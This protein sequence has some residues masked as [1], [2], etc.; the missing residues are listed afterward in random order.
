MIAMIVHEL[1]TNAVKCGALSNGTGRLS[2][3]WGQPTEF[4]L[5]ELAWQENG[6]PEVSAPKER[7][8]GSHL[9]ERAFGG[10]LGGAQLM[11]CPSGLRCTIKIACFGASG[12]RSAMGH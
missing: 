5:V 4:D 10:Q 11:F 3:T 7:G 2:V 9:I 12:A 6:G 8:F 1:A